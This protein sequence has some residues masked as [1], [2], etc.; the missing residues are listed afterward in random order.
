ML[1]AHPKIVSMKLGNTRSAIAMD[2]YGGQPLLS[3]VNKE[4][5][6]RAYDSRVSHACVSA[7]SHPMCLTISPPEAQRISADNHLMNV[8]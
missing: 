8:G 5:R 3:N 6:R 2:T 7:S 4:E 1:S